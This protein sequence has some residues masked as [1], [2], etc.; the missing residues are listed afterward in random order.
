MGDK[1][2]T[3]KASFYFNPITDTPG[4]PED[5]KKYPLS[6]PCNIW[7]H[8]EKLPEFKDKAKVLGSILTDACVALA[9]N[10]DAYVGKREPGVTKDLLTSALADTEKVKGRLLY[11]FPL[12]ANQSASE[13]SWVS[14]Q[15]R[16]QPAHPLN[17]LWC[18]DRMA[19]RQWIPHGA[20][21]RLVSR[22]FHGNGICLS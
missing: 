15:E 17:N 6:Y 16:G 7:P 11:Y 1:P 18:I 9:K 21:W 10:L 12:P 2:D 13:D 5:R 14:G 8:H 19:Q 4:T 22:P 3:A 20:C